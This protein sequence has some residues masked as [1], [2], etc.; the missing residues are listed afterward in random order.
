MLFF[1]A[2]LLLVCFTASAVMLPFFRSTGHLGVMPVHHRQRLFADQLQQL[3]DDLARGAIDVA[4]YATT[5]AEVGRRLIAISREDGSKVAPAE[6]KSH[7]AAALSIVVPVILLAGFGYLLFG[8]PQ[9]RD[10]PLNAR[11]AAENPDLPILIAK[12]ERHLADMPQDGRGW[13]L[14]APIYFREGDFD[15]AEIAYS[16]AIAI[17]GPDADRLTGAGEA[18]VAA[19]SGVVT[20]RALEFFNQALA[21]PGDHFRAS[22]YQALAVEQ[23]GA[24]EKALSLFMAMRSLPQ[25]SERWSALVDQHI[26][27]N[28]AAVV[29]PGTQDMLGNAP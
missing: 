12:V 6:G 3:E 29:S 22:F 27:L 19:A 16:R 13:E 8:A 15:K 18:L 25:P 4:E 1:I 26:A 11:L 21:F 17:L 10:M 14:I 5:R 2:A 7:F 23:S 20:D 9:M 24:H 28:E